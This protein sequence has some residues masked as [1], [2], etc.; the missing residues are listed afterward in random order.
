MIQSAN[1]FSL[2][3]AVR[4]IRHSPGFI[5]RNPGDD[6]GMTV[7]P[8]EHFHPFACQS[9]NR[10]S[11]IAVCTGHL[12]PHQKTHAIGPVE[13]ARVL[14]FLVFAHSIEAQALYEENVLQE[15]IIVRG[16]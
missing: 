10:F 9:F 2:L 4:E 3:Y 14:N 1:I 16:S 6:A 7:V 15:S 12:F 13:K 11:R 8:I 5:E